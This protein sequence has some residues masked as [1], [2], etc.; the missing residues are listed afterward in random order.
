MPDLNYS[1]DLSKNKAGHHFLLSVM[2]ELE[3]E[4]AQDINI[5]ERQHLST[6]DFGKIFFGVGNTVVRARKR[7]DL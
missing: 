6:L 3:G 7:K 4:D 5:V 2:E 1:V